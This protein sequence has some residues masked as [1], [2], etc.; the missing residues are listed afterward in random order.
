MGKSRKHMSARE[1]KQIQELHRQGVSVSNIAERLNRSPQSIYARLRT[2]LS[3]QT[4]PLV[5]KSAE[6]T[7]K[8]LDMHLVRTIINARSLSD[9]TKLTVLRELM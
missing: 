3:V 6:E 5:E 8:I 7:T 2:K 4:R 9:T 1:L